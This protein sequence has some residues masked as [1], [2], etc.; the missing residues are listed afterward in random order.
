MKFII[1]GEIFGDAQD[2]QH[3]LWL[4][5]WFLYLQYVDYRF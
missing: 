5:H 4:R 1:F 2:D 3:D